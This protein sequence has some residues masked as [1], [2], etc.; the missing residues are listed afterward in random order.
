MGKV[1]VNFFDDATHKTNLKKYFKTILPI[2][3]PEPRRFISEVFLIY[4]IMYKIS[5]FY[6]FRNYHWLRSYYN[7]C[8]L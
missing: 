7:L 3:T 6:R 2:Q 5:R 8:L 1:N 4:D